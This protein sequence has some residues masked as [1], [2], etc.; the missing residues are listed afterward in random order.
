MEDK[1]ALSEELWKERE[2]INKFESKFEVYP[3]SEA[4]NLLRK[5]HD[6]NN[7]IEENGVPKTSE[8]LL[9]KELK[10]R[11]KTESY[12]LEKRINPKHHDFES[13][14]AIFGI[15]QEDLDGLE[16]Y[17][18]ENRQDTINAISRLYKT[19][20][21][22]NYELNVSMDIPRIRR[23]AE[24]FAAVHIQRY[25]KKL[26]NFLQELTQAGSFLRDIDAVPTLKGRSYFWPLTKTF[27]LGISAICMMTEDSSLHIKEKELIRL[28]GHE[29]MGHALNQVITESSDLPYFLKQDSTTNAPTQESIAQF[30][31]RVIFEDLK[32][33]SKTQ[34]DLGIEHKFEDIYQEVLDQEQLHNYHSRLFYYTITVLADKTLGM[35]ADRE[36]VQ[37]KIEILKKVSINPGYPLHIVEKYRQS[38]D[39]HGNLDSGLVKEL[40][41]C[42][43]PVQRALE[44]FKKQGILYDSE[45]RSKIDMTLL[46][47][48][49][50]PQG[51]VENATLRAQE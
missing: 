26:G 13:V 4:E 20:E 1:L 6:L 12:L 46:A 2:R 47:G 49:W 37:K 28:Y 29:G 21:V 5:I 39:S 23:Q 43:Q 50:T 19:R 32:N 44:E 16:E 38:F 8:Q 42:A 9:L 48:Y 17:L 51:F 40:I 14:V 11:L 10:R 30:Y 34:K 18:L 45:G 3:Y 25:H 31:Q 7:S 35:Q 33:S 27:A 41:Y 15:P 22:L 36:T 24:E